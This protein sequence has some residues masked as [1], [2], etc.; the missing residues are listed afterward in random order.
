MSGFNITGISPKFCHITTIIRTKWN[1]FVFIKVR[2]VVR[3]TLNEH[4][5][6]E[7]NNFLLI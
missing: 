6:K 1:A 7:T 3:K 5:N 4:M 2:L